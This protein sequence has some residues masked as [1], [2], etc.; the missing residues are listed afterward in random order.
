MKHK[1]YSDD[2]KLQVVN[3]YLN[4]PLGCRLLARKYNLP[5]KNYILKWK[6]QLIKKGLL[7]TGLV[8][9]DLIKTNKSISKKK[10]KTAYEKQLER[11]NF[12]LKARLAYYQE[13]DRLLKEDNKKK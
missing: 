6:D 8:K 2:F 11:E 3:E 1:E 9:K 10:T 4:G 12:E 13:L 7:E 5:S